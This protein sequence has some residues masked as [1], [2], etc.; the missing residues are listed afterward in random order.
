LKAP[1]PLSARDF[2]QNRV[3]I[4]QQIASFIGL[5]APT[6]LQARCYDAMLDHYEIV[7]ALNSGLEETTGHFAQA[8]RLSIW[9]RAELIR[10]LMAGEKIEGFTWDEQ[11]K[12][13][14]FAFNLDISSDPTP[15]EQARI[16]KSEQQSLHHAFNYRVDANGVGNISATFQLNAGNAQ[17]AILSP[18]TTNDDGASRKRFRALLSNISELEIPIILSDQNAVQSP[19]AIARSAF[20]PCRGLADKWTQL[21]HFRD[22]PLAQ[23]VIHETTEAGIVDHFLGSADRRWFC[24]G[25]ANYVAWSLA[26]NRA[27]LDFART[28]YDLDWNLAHFAKFQLQ[29][30]LQKWPA[31]ERQPEKDAASQLSAAHYAFATRAIVTMAQT[32]GED[33]VP[34]LLREIG[35]TPRSK[36]SMKTV[37]KAYEKVTKAK[38]DSL[39]MRAERAPISKSPSETIDR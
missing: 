12:T 32:Y 17:P 33:I 24:E 22:G 36:A 16:G 8:H 21:A 13:G 1:L 4:L 28:V 6:E 30:D 15:E 3:A 26:R 31:A 39:V 10:R 29:I 11:K 37:A 2:R 38:L 14:A 34:R 9:E 7:A 19:N 25:T 20:E 18:T 27:G 23:I 5:D 35:K